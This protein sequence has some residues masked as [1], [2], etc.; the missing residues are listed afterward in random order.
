[1]LLALLAL[2]S[3]TWVVHRLVIWRWSRIDASRA[4]AGEE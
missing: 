2:P 1:M 4:T 3:L